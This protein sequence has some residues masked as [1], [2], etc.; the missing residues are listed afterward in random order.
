LRALALAADNELLTP[1]SRSVL[2]SP[3]YRAPISAL[4]T[5]KHILGNF[6]LRLSGTS[7]TYQKTATLG[8]EESYAP[9]TDI[10]GKQPFALVL[11]WRCSIELEP[12]LR[13]LRTLSSLAARKTSLRRTV[14]D[15]PMAIAKDCL[16]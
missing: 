14:G 16:V 2:E 9:S 13:G 11:S 12:E 4:I 3:R 5:R 15:A 7:C 1:S 8:D 10:P 6:R